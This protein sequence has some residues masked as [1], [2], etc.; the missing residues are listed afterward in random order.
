MNRGLEMFIDALVTNG[1]EH[2]R[3]FYGPRRAKVVRND[4][5]EKRG[6]IQVSA[7]PFG[8]GESLDRWVDP[9]F[10]GT[11]PD[12]G[13]FWPPEVGDVVWVRFDR[14]RPDSPL[15]YEGGWHG[16]KASGNLPAEF[17]TSA[18]SGAANEVPT[19]RGIVTRMGH[20]LIF[21]EEQGKESIRLVCHIPAATDPAH[22]DRS[23]SA[24]RST[25]TWSTLFFEPNGDIRLTNDVGS[26]LWLDAE[27][28]EVKL[29][30][31]D[32]TKS[33]SITMSENG[34]VAIDEA[35]NSLGLLKDK[36]TVVAS[37][38]VMVTA[39]SFTADTG[40]TNLSRN[41]TQQV[42]HGNTWTIARA[43]M[44]TKVAAAHQLAGAF[45]NTQGLAAQAT[46]AALAALPPTP[47]TGT[48]VAAALTPFFQAIAPPAMVAGQAEG[49]AG[50]A[51]TQ[52][53]A[54]APTYLSKV[55]KTA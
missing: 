52:F 48:V 15:V 10:D 5:P 16:T 35:G 40:S 17:A 55:T 29:I 32:G 7:P 21:A 41:A 30:H 9:S 51:V 38:P 1:L 27:N 50:A 31:K 12:R 23:K 24:N 42:V 14:G 26:V 25:G 44:N 34:I 46:V 54:K 20:M 4:D 28:N 22:T 3:S 43:G 37:V 49:Q 33:N 47:V 53:E 6:R 13:Q 18:V 39:P 2:F 19:R 8:E 11:G 36:V 45:H